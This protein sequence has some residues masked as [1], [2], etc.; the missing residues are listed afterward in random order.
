MIENSSLDRVRRSLETIVGA[1]TPD[2]ATREAEL[3]RRY[4][5]ASVSPQP[6]S[7]Y[8]SNCATFSRHYLLPNLVKN[9]HL[10]LQLHRLGLLQ[11]CHNVLDLGAGPGT[12]AFS[13]LCWLQ[14]QHKETN[15]E[16]RVS[17]VDAVEEFRG[18][19]DSIW[20]D[21]RLP[22]K[23]GLLPRQVT[24][25]IKGDV[26]EH[27]DKPELIVFSNSL[28]EIL[29]NS[30]VDHGRLIDSL[31]Q[32]QAVTA[33]VDYD[34][35]SVS[36]FFKEFAAEMSSVFH[37]VSCGD[38]PL[39][40]GAYEQ[41]DLGC[42]SQINASLRARRVR[43]L[44]SVW[45]PKPR[46]FKLDAVSANDLVLTYKR[47]WEHHDVELLSELFAEDAT[48]VERQDRRPFFG[49][50]E[51]KTYWQ[52]NALHQASVEFE[53]LSIDFSD[54]NLLVG[55]RC[56]FFRKDLSQWLNL[57]GEFEAV[58]CNG[59]ISRFVEKFDKKMSYLRD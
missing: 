7:F 49:L 35:E 2:S 52:R 51:I 16:F 11:D 9:H 18:V 21:L 26:L 45:I 17:M 38:W 4:F 5:R 59:R 33:I 44:N 10:V 27:A 32:A 14:S 50:S 57:E 36:P 55:W 37:K 19:F 23:D 40:H 39:R 41:V 31:V 6:Q 15:R 48:Y 58:V 43:C 25:F 1:S 54:H 3:F 20:K 42:L 8:V 34:Y 47:A 28:G 12:F 53:P 30:E 22:A 13:L 24:A 29:R 56:Q 46:E